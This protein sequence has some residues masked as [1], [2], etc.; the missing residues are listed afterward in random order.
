[1]EPS[2]A[3]V[4]PVADSKTVPATFNIASYLPRMACADPDRP[5]VFVTGSRDS[6]G[7]AV[8]ASMTFA[9]LEAESNRYANG[10]TKT[11]IARGMRV[12]VMVR[13]GF[14]FVGLI[15]ALFKMGAVPVMIDPGMGVGRMLDCIRMV[16]LHAFIGVPLAHMIRILRPGAFITVEHAVTG[17]RRW[18]WG[19][20]TVIAG[21]FAPG[22]NRTT[23]SASLSRVSSRLARC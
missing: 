10:L 2:T 16:D 5:A 8:Y 3:H 23:E 4:E 7:R 15:F 14:E 12:L 20:P 22:T 13:P 9:Q 17:G 1:M 19:G 11:G 18:G 6:R 21:A